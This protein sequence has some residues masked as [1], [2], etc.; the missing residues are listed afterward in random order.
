MATKHKYALI[1]PEDIGKD[2][3]H[4][5]NINI[6]IHSDLKN[7]NNPSPV[8]VKVATDMVDKDIGGLSMDEICHSIS[9]LMLYHLNLIP[10]QYQSTSKVEILSRLVEQIKNFQKVEK[11][12][13]V[14]NEN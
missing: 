1:D 4:I 3:T 6:A 12:E 9:A 8:I 14:S 10:V 5:A 2:Y 13:K 11:S 7:K